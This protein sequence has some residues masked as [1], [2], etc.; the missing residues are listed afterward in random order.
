MLLEMV[1]FV[2]AEIGADSRGSLAVP[3]YRS[4]QRFMMSN[5]SSHDDVCDSLTALQRDGEMV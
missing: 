4:Q 1:H 3:S 2:T 5:P